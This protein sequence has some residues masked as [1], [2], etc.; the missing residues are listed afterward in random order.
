MMEAVK[1]NFKFSEEKFLLGPNAKFAGLDL[2]ANPTGWV[3]TKP[4]RKR[5][6]ALCNLQQLESK[7]E[8]QSLLGLIST[9]NKWVPELSLKGK[10]IRDLGKKKVIFKW[11]VDRQ[12]CFKEVKRAIS[13]NIPLEPFDPAANSIVFTDA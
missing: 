1:E 12:K 7:K 4:D 5:I 13:D 3:T 9:F 2:S 11:T 6:E 10:L 8:V